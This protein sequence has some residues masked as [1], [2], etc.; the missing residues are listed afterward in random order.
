M[1]DRTIE[2]RS[3]YF[4]I[5]RFLVLL[6]DIQWSF[7]KEMFEVMPLQKLKKMKH[8]VSICADEKGSALVLA[9]LILVLLT[10][11]GISATTTSTVGVQ[12]A[13]SEKSYELAFYSAESGWQRA[14]NWLDDQYPGV[15]D[16]LVWDGTD[17][18]AVAGSLDDAATVGIP[19]AEDN[20][21][22]YFVKVEFAGTTPVPG[23]GTSFRRFNYR[24]NSVGAGPG[25][26]RS[27]VQVTAG[28]VF[29]MEGY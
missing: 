15:T 3:A 20:N 5:L 11:M 14:L 9:L 4:I 28:K 24:V 13:G 12:M 7:S 18:I 17:F 21:T 19:L 23:Y 16:N 8:I 25:N 22:Q 27:E 29:D 6:F 10:L 2:Y 1:R 26:A